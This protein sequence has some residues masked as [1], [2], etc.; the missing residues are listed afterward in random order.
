QASAQPLRPA[1]SSSTRWLRRHPQCASLFPPR[2]TPTGGSTNPRDRRLSPA[3]YPLHPSSQTACSS[4]A[5]VAASAL[6]ARCTAHPPP[7][8]R[9]SSSPA[10][11]S[12]ARTAAAGSSVATRCPSSS[13]TTKGKT[14][15]NT[16]CTPQKKVR[17]SGEQ[18][19]SI[20]VSFPTS[21][22]HL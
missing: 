6:S 1:V 7:T 16:K 17:N 10:S 19:K 3:Q 11:C 22:S 12:D 4:D 18:S 8:H 5:S 13:N 2:C 14:H 21:L 15:K 9:P 20:L